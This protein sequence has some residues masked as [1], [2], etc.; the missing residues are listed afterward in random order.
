MAY[1]IERLR[2]E[3][4]L[5]PTR[6]AQGMQAQ[7]IANQVSQFGQ[8]LAQNESQ[9]A[10]TKEQQESQFT[11][12]LDQTNA[13]W[14]ANFELAKGN[15]EEQKRQFGVTTA[16]QADQFEKNITESKRQFDANYTIAKDNLKLALDNAQTQK[17]QFAAQMAF[18]REVQAANAKLQQDAADAAKT[19]G[20]TGTI[21]NTLLTAAMLR[22]TTM[23]K[24]APFFGETVG[25][26]A[27]KVWNGITGGGTAPT[28]MDSS[29][30]NKLPSFGEGSPYQFN[31]GGDS[32]FMTN[33]ALEGGINAAPAA[34]PTSGAI[35]PMNAGPA[36]MYPT[37][38]TGGVPYA[39]ND[40]GGFY[41][42]LTPASYTAPIDTAVPSYTGQ[43]YPGIEEGF[44]AG[45]YTQPSSTAGG[46]F[47]GM[48]GT[49]AGGASA[50]S[51]LGVAAPYVAAATIGMP[52]LGNMSSRAF[53]GLG[54]GKQG[55]NSVMQQTARV[56][57]RGPEGFFVPAAEEYFGWKVPEVVN[58]FV[59]PAGYLLKSLSKLF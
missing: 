34:G 43:V 50:G 46:F 52:I 28:A 24:G 35:A 38:S 8:T 3:Y 4:A 10:R 29:L 56:V 19:S 23:E 37:T 51:I 49:A 22:A 7:Q 11:R 20:I 47:S 45:A 17:D 41:D 42:G 31:F 54:W 9:F 40:V 18:N 2:S 12:G 30:V 25:N 15:A 21:G 5:A 59:N 32:P 58:A 48:G 26:A 6:A 14:L 33:P 53:E 1:E 36:S 16:A 57:G 27:S 39:S 55:D 44:G 13:Q